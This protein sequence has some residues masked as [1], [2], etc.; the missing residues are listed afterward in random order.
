MISS[1]IVIKLAMK[2]RGTIDFKAT[3][4]FKERTTKMKEKI[5]DERQ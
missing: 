2:T 1:F 5:I 3:L 4:S